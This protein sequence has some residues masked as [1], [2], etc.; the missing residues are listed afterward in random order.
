MN[1]VATSVS[2]GKPVAVGIMHT[3]GG[4]GHWIVVTGVTPN[5]DFIVHDPFGKL[6][7]SR[8]GG[9]AYANSGSNQAGRNAVYSRDF[10][11][12]IFEDRGPGTGRIMRIA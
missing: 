8:G 10:M 7:Q 9:W 2:S 6:V 4:S 3:P 1:E 12:S 5:G 11:Y